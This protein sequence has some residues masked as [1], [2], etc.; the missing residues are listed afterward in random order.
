MKK[1]LLPPI[2]RTLLSPDN[3]QS[4]PYLD[5]NFSAFAGGRMKIKRTEI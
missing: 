2:F 4:G 1:I 5:K 3:T